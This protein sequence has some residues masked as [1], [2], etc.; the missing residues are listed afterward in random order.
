M[1]LDK[2]DCVVDEPEIERLHRDSDSD[3]HHG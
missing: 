3:R 2:R 1:K